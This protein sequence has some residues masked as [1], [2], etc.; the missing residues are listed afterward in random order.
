MSQLYLSRSALA[1][2]DHAQAEL[3][4]HLRVDAND[5]IGAFCAAH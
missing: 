5:F 4:A 2:L 3:D 1:E